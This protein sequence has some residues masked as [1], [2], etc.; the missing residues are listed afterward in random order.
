ML[1]SAQLLEHEVEAGSIFKE[2]DEFQDIPE[3][4]TLT[5]D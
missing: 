2:L 3:R 4:N 1:T 5:Q